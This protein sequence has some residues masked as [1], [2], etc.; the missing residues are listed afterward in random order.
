MFTIRWIDL[1]FVLAAVLSNLLVAAIFV[2][3]KHKRMELVRKLG[4]GMLLLG[5][6]FAAVFGYYLLEGGHPAWVL[7]Y[8]VL[9]LAYLFIEW[10][11]DYA[12]K[13]DFR[14]RWFTHVPYILLEYG[15]L[16][17]LVG[18][19]FYIHEGWGWVLT[20][21]FWLLLGC[22]VYLYWGSWKKK[23]KCEEKGEEN[24]PPGDSV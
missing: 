10:L 15:M 11:L 16:F 14:S 1:V 2:A 13:V 12:L 6:A 7:V 17:G 21:T 20:G 23:G 3:S 8:F 5:L 18:I 24:C 4:T 19:S 22:L 9:I